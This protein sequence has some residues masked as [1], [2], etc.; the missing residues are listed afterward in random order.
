MR[1]D[2]EVGDFEEIAGDVVNPTIVGQVSAKMSV[3]FNAS[4]EAV[5]AG[6]R[7]RATARG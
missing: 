7:I 2:V 3:A 4:A 5:V 6:E 1:G